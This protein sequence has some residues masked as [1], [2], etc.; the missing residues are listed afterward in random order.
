MWLVKRVCTTTNWFPHIRAFHDD[1]LATQVRRACIIFC[2]NSNMQE[3][4]CKARFL[5]QQHIDAL[6]HEHNPQIDCMQRLCS[7]EVLPDKRAH[8]IPMRRF[9]TEAVA[10]LNQYSRVPHSR[11][12][13][14]CLIHIRYCIGPV[15]SVIMGTRCSRYSLTNLPPE[16]ISNIVA[17]ASSDEAAVASVLS[18]TCRWLRSIVLSSITAVK[19][20]R[21]GHGHQIAPLLQR[22][23]GAVWRRI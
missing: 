1:I 4:V 8:G 19:L 9:S 21:F 17:V 2:N 18:A 12:S 22:L 11:V 6:T 20:Q 3:A 10:H 7:S 23:T 15:R 5:D 16:V 13:E 14:T